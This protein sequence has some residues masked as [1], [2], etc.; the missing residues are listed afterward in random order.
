MRIV[1]RRSLV[2]L[3]VSE[4]WERVESYQ[5]PQT[6]VE[7]TGIQQPALITVPHCSCEEVIDLAVSLLQSPL[8]TAQL[9]DSYEESQII[10]LFILL[11]F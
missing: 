7:P 4:C 1:Y 3:S 6:G 5:R 8:L 2:F 10:R 11:S 9:I